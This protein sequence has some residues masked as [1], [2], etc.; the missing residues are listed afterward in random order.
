MNKLI[1]PR[2]LL[3]LALLLLPFRATIAQE[4]Q[5]TAEA[6]LKKMRQAYGNLTAYH[7]EHTIV[8][9]AKEDNKQPTKL[10][11]VTLVTASDKIEMAERL[12]D[13][14]PVED[15]LS[16]V[17]HHQLPSNY[18]RLHM[19]VRHPEN[20]VVLIHN[21][22]AKTMFVGKLNEYK[23]GEKVLSSV[24]GAMYFGIHMT[25]FMKLT[26]DSL[27]GAK[28][29]KQE[30]IVVGN[31]KHKCHVVEANVKLSPI[32]LPE[33]TKIPEEIAS[34]DPYAGPRGVLMILMI[35]GFIDKKQIGLFTSANQDELPRRRLWID[36]DGIIWR[37]ELSEK[38]R[39]RRL[40]G[41]ES[42]TGKVV[43]LI[44]TDLFSMATVNRPLPEE[45]FQFTPPEGAK[46]VEK[47]TEPPR[48]KR[49]K[50]ERTE[51]ESSKP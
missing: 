30:E 41:D 35:H 34:D 6:I 38:V 13:E 14:K 2:L 50:S 24:A 8:I 46:E 49:A 11:E 1:D 36:N 28:I 27:Q 44:A 22:D 32:P 40:D 10:A 31:E 25:T 15:R 47:F 51:T 33:G 20:N 39:V 18:R 26:D 42:D 5:A 21:G 23:T 17:E 29:I 37:S 9:E 45:L 7:F 48:P 43:E 4:D 3:C 16:A 12:L 19:E